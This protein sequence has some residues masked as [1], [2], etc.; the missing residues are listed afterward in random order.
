MITFALFLLFFV[1]LIQTFRLFLSYDYLKNNSLKNT[2]FSSQHKKMFLLIPVLNEQKVIKESV[3]HFAKFASDTIEIVYITSAKEDLKGANKTTHDILLELQKSN[4]ISVIKCP[5][6]ENAIMAHQLNYAVNEIAKNN[7]DFIIS[8]YNVDSKTAKETLL[9]I[10]NSIEKDRK[11]V[12]QQFTF[13]PFTKPNILSHIALWQNRWTLHFELGRLLFDQMVLKTFYNRYAP[14][15]SRLLR[16]L[17]YVIGHGLFFDYSVYKD[18][19]GFAEDETNEDA[20]L[21]YI[22]YTKGYELSTVPCLEKADIAKSI[23]V[24][25]KQQ[26]VWFNGPF[27]AFKYFFRLLKKQNN[28]RLKRDGFKTIY[29]K[30]D[31]F[32]GAI[33][34]FLHS[35]YWLFGPIVILVLLP[36]AVFI[37]CPLSYFFVCVLL[38]IY[39]AF[40][41]NM[42]TYFMM[43][44]LYRNDFKFMP[45]LMLKAIIAYALHAVGPMMAVYKTIIRKNNIKH[46]YKTEK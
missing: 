39:H 13:Y 34:L 9:Y 12:F 24:Y 31:G 25:L 41:I 35:V 40:G 27:M 28:N 10:A 20:F 11:K 22:M 42:I 36:F 23:K 14:K 44:K 43:K 7:N 26:S 3:E 4:R 6:T 2:Y 21:G 18:V 8:L 17:H 33:K 5:I 15:L 1:C 19:S 45:A 32:L 29:E 37:T 38:S 16:P 30:I 46:K